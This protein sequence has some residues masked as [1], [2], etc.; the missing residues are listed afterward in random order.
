MTL[1]LRLAVATVAGWLLALAL[2]YFGLLITTFASVG[3]SLGAPP[4]DPSPGEYAVLLT[5]A[6]VGAAVGAQI[7]ARLARSDA[8]LALLGLALGLA[9]TYWWGFRGG[10]SWPEWWAPT[11]ALAAVLGVWAGTLGIRRQ[12]A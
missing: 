8:S 2:A 12:P 4:R 7:T 10:S 11:V 6:G 5:I 9:A 3:A 1:V